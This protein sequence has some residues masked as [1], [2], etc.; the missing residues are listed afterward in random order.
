VKYQ[1]TESAFKHGIYV[2]QMIYIMDNY[3]SFTIQPKDSRG[4]KVKK[5]GWVARDFN[6][7]EI[8]MVA[9]STE[10]YLE[11]IHAMPRDFNKKGKPDGSDLS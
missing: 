4:L 6:G 11:V 2:D 7:L 3:P 8:E 5:I 10:F 9:I 1:F